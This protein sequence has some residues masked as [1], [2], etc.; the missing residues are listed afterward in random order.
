MRFLVYGATKGR[1]DGI[2]RSCAVELLARGHEVHGLCRDAAKASTE[3]AFS[4]EAV[5]LLARSGQERIKALVRELDPDVVWSACG[6][7]FATPLWSMPD[8]EVEEMIDANIRNNIVLCRTCMPSCLDGGPHLV[9]TG[10]ASGVLEGMGAAVYSGAKGF[11]VPFVR[12]QRGEYRRQ[13][14]NP[15]LSLLLLH[16][17]RSTGLDLVVD[18]L[19]FVGRQ[20]H[21]LELLVA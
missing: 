11:L 20:T 15:K 9:L 1:G 18:A 12:A 3:G 7:G 10:S 14:H 4:L 8:D 2:G 19:E 16:A 6:V 21:S 5:D 13:G 17:V